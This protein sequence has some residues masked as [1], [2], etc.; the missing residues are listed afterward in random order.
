MKLLSD[1]TEVSL[2]RLHEVIT[3]RISE[4]ITPIE[5]LI[6]SS[7]QRSDLQ[8]SQS[9]GG[10]GRWPPRWAYMQVATCR[11]RYIYMKLCTNPTSQWHHM[12][13]KLLRKSM[14]HGGVHRQQ[15]GVTHADLDHM[16]N[17]HW[18]WVRKS[19]STHVSVPL[20]QTLTR[21]LSIYVDVCA[22]IDI[23]KTILQRVLRL[24]IE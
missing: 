10:V 18:R 22:S 8:V 11:E 19:M 5:R 13:S 2:Q 3:S 6:A 23:L 7:M 20:T 16:I 12:A 15:Y 21:S 9:C 1:L 17:V 24:Y 4:Y 14:K